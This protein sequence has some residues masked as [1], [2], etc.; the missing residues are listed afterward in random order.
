MTMKNVLSILYLTTAVLTGCCAF[1]QTPA[2]PDQFG[3]HHWTATVKVIGEDGNPIDGVD[4][5]AQ[6]TVPTP[7]N[8]GEQTYGEVKGTTDTNGVF[9]ASH[10][11]SSWDLGVVAEKAGYYGSHTGYQFYFDEKRRNPT[12]TLM[13]KKIAR[14][15]AMYA[16]YVENGPPVFNEP[17]G[18]DLM[19]GDWVAPHGKGVATD[20][21]FTGQLDKKSRN[22]FDY[23][24]IVSFPKP[25]DGIQGFTTSDIEKTSELRSPHEAPLDGYQPQITRACFQN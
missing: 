12:F 6:Y 20:I 16:K 22:D 8:S 18:Y 14:P 9:I 19:V 24:L 1:G 4:V 2:L 5:E 23:K 25:G 11:D 10:T 7:P 17:V 21:I 13:L 15:I 3:P